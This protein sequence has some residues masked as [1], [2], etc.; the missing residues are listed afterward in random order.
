MPL[1]PGDAPR[2]RAPTRT[3]ARRSI[4]PLVLALVLPV[5]VGC[6]AAAPP[7]PQLVASPTELP[8][9]AALSSPVA[10]SPPAIAEVTP[11]VPAVPPPTVA[12][13][14]TG[15]APVAASPP[16]GPERV[17]V[18]N[19]EGQGANLREE[20]APGAA[21]IKTI[22]EGTELDVIGPDREG[23][24]RTWRNV[25]DPVDGASGWVVAELLTPLPARVTGA[26]PA[27]AGASPA[28]SPAADRTPSATAPTGPVRRIGDADRAYLAQLQPEV[29]TLGKGIAAVNGQIEAAAGRAAALEEAAW[30]AAADAAGTSLAAA[31][32]RIRAARPGPETGE[33]H[34]R[35]LRAAERAD[36]AARLLSEAI[37]ARDP[38]R[39]GPVR[40]ALLRVV[41]EINAM[42]SALI[43]LQ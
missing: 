18:A 39:F 24:G 28:P 1:P 40:T 30:R 8:A 21:R 10:L 11:T 42:N 13:L 5:G 43:Q 26:A 19:S 12:V 32:R 35:A 36:E 34:E 2:R 22:R 29:D 16:A 33:V 37:E 25:R 15:G 41:S 31:A 38:R 14:P 20:P 9:P 6:G 3:P 23:D 7:S 4:G 17:R 27:P